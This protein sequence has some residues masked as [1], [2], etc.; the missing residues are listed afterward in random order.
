[1][2]LQAEGDLFSDLEAAASELDS[3]EEPEI[4]APPT[5]E[6]PN[7]P[8]DGWTDVAPSEAASEQIEPAM[9]SPTVDGVPQNQPAVAPAPIQP[10]PVAAPTDASAMS[11]PYPIQPEMAAAPAHG[12]EPLPVLVPTGQAAVGM[13]PESLMVEQ[14]PPRASFHPRN[15]RGLLSINGIT[16]T[17]RMAQVGLNPLGLTLAIYTTWYLVVTIAAAISD[18][19]G[20]AWFGRSCG[21]WIAA[22]CG[23]PWLEWWTQKR[24][25]AEIIWC[26]PWIGMV[27]LNPKVR[28]KAR[29]IVDQLSISSEEREAAL[30]MSPSVKVRK[31]V[32]WLYLAVFLTWG[33]FTH[34]DVR[35]FG[36]MGVLVL[37]P[38]YALQAVLLADTF[39]LF[40]GIMPLIKHREN[41]NIV[42][43]H[44]GGAAGIDS[45][46]QILQMFAG[47]PVYF[48]MM[49]IIRS[50]LFLI[51]GEGG[52]G[53]EDAFRAMGEVIVAVAFLLLAVA[54]SMGPLLLISGSVKRRKQNLIGELAERC[55]FSSLNID[56][57][58]NAEM[59]DRKVADMLLMERIQAIRPIDINSITIIFKKIAIPAMLALIRPLMGIV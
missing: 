47:V 1:M 19:D 20:T 23:D 46:T 7:V 32:F 49:M 35:S 36:L 53:E 12:G 37:W 34:F 16:M 56:A 50:Y 3:T 33:T 6:A 48:A 25:W 57:M 55:G 18:A 11:T 28:E 54:L 43:F 39:S 40:A 59:D 30:Q 5:E 26:T 51:L 15:L 21:V 31:A 29:G 17:E 22:E 42:P 45:I 13:A 10:E 4:A 52:G 38:V 24:I 8:S 44:P 27:I 58:L 2:G 9:T 41:I 14:N